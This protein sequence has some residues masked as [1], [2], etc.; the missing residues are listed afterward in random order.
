MNIV[1]SEFMEQAAVAALSARHRVIYEPDL[2]HDLPRMAELMTDCDALIVRNRTQVNADLLSLAADLSIVGR[3]GMSMDNID[4]AACV[5]RNVTVVSAAGADAISVA[6]YVIG[7]ILNMRR[8]VFG[9]SDEVAGGRWPRQL[10]ASGAEVFAQTLGLVGFGHT[11]RQTAQIA[12][13]LGMR[14]LAHDPAISVDA[15]IWGLN[16]TRPGDLSVLLSESDFVSLHVPLTSDTR[17]LIGARQVALMK[18]GA[19]LINTSRGGVVD[20][21]A[22]VAALQSGHLGGVAFDVFEREPLPADSIWAAAPNA[23]LTPHIAGLTPQS[24]AR[25][26]D[27][28]ARKILAHFEA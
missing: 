18:P 27:L 7:A 25:A 3:L 1:I 16:G 24:N 26:S 21:A 5:A 10:G 28:V 2:V 9:L 22:V 4:T 15:A 11:A 23:L 13:G 6:E 14:V 19:F 20:E 17:G 8:N 12:R